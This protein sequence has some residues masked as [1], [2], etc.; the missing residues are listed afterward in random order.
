MPKKAGSEMA[1]RGKLADVRRGRAK[2]PRYMK[3]TTKKGAYKKTAKKN[4]QIRRAPFVETKTR[5]HEEMS[6][7][8]DPAV[9]PVNAIPNPILPSMLKCG[10]SEDAFHIFTPL[11]FNS[12]SQGVKEDT[13]LGQ[14]VYSRYLKMKVKFMFPQN[15]WSINFPVD[16]YLIHGFVTAPLALTANTTQ[17][18]DS[19]NRPLLVSY[20]QQHVKQYFDDLSDDMRFIPKTTTNMKILGYQKIRPNI[21]RSIAPP[22]LVQYDG[23]GTSVLGNLPDVKRSINWPTNRKVR[24]TQGSPITSAAAGADHNTPFL[25]PNESWLPFACVYIP[26]NDS[27]GSAPNDKNFINISYNDIHYFSDS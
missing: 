11:S 25:Y 19:L 7:A 5:T 21:N 16:I 8:I 2:P 14:S 13:M 20:L 27:W 26:Q 4:F 12:M 1:V 6:N 9:D 18:Q 23:Q 24:Y 3:R 22:N 15:T 17:T 10:T